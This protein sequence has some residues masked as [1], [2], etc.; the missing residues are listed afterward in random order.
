MGQRPTIP[1]PVDVWGK[2]RRRAAQALA[3]CE[4]FANPLRNGMELSTTEAHAV[5]LAT[6]IIRG[7][8]S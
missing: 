6:K 8:V 5:R 1:T 7:K 2:R 4:E 3:L